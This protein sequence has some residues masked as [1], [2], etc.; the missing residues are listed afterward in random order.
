[1]QVEAEIEEVVHRTY[2]APITTAKRSSSGAIT[3][4][5]PML[6]FSHAFVYD[7]RQL[8]HLFAQSRIFLD[9]ALNAFAIAPQLFPQA[10]KLTSEIINFAH[11]IFRYSAEHLAK[12]LSRYFPIGI[13]R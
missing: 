4:L 7:L 1:L 13:T 11:R 9:F 3:K 8:R 2:Q 5:S 6:E 12:I 10:L